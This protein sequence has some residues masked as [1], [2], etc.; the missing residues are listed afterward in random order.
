MFVLFTIP[1]FIH[2]ISVSM[3][4]FFFLKHSGCSV[5]D[6][7]KRYRNISRRLLGDY[8]LS[9]QRVNGDLDQEGSSGDEKWWM[10]MA[11]ILEMNHLNLN[12]NP[13]YH[14]LVEVCTA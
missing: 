9:R 2:Y 8:I 13:K 4:F 11:Y 7:L 10:H 5:N 6:G 12:H 14:A 3:T 1:N